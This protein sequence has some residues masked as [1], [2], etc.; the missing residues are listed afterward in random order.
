M[1]FANESETCLTSVTAFSERMNS[2]ASL[3][4]VC[5]CVRLIFGA[6]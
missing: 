6:G 5:E 4:A 1:L 3:C 2:H